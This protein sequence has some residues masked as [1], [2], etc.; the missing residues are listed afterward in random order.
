MQDIIFLGLG[1][2]AWITIASVLGVF[3]TMLFT[4]TKTHVAFICVM[5]VLCIS[6]VLTIEETFA[7]Y[8]ASSI[9]TI[10]LLF[11][12]IAALRH[13]GALDWMVSHLM[14]QPKTYSL[15]ILR[16]MLPVGMLS[17]FLSNTATTALFNDIVKKWSAKLGLSPSKLLIPLAYA[18]S[19]GGVMT[20]IGTPGNLLIAGMYAKDSHETINI[21]AP[22]PVAIC[23]LLT[24]VT[25]IILFKRFLP[26]RTP[27]PMAND[28]A[29][30]T[31][32]A[33]QRPRRMTFLSMAIMAGVLVLPALKV[34][35]LPQC[36]LLACVLV[37]VFRCCTSEQA[38]KEVDWDILLVFV[39]SMCIGKAIDKTG[40][41]D[42]VIHLILNYCDSNPHLALIM[43][44]ATAALATEF[45]SDTACAAMFYPITFEAATH[46]GVNPVP[47]L[48]VLMM[49]TSNNYATPIAT[50]PNT[51]VYNSGGYRF[52]DFARLGVPL[53]IINLA[54]AIT[55]SQ[56]F[57]P[58]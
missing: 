56:I 26:N 54:I 32:S 51:L 27:S 52:A 18:T 41:D 6:G 42:K 10:G 49:S 7:G 40:L 20:L 23:C 28:D 4:N 30:E 24:S 11:P 35:E 53:K 46:L 55:V 36:C 9:I 17:S 13:T 14:G 47:F 21:F 50:P 8:D 44:A 58:L 22:F 39:G 43:L 25:F 1:L 2:D 37:V 33:T 19:F 5:A 15:A 57:Y 34:M 48:I 16:L 38:I 31:T 29:Q 12:V 45:I 3:L